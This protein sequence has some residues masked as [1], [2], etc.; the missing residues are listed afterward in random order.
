MVFTDESGKSNELTN[1]DFESFKQK[2]PQI[3][4]MLVQ[5]D[6]T[7]SDKMIKEN[8]EKDTWEKN[9]KKILNTI[10]KIKGAFYFHT[11]V[12]PIKLKIDDY[13]DIVKKPMDFG[14]VKVNNLNFEINLNLRINSTPTSILV[15]KS[16]LTMLI[17]KLN[18]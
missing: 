17:C 5:A 13:L 15:R 4:Q 10:W 1:T 9:A 2:Y 18:K 8:K 12:D 11:P 3:A 16:L 7:I 6:T 14:T